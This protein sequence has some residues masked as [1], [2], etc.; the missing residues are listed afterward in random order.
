MGEIRVFKTLTK[1][2]IEIIN[3]EMPEFIR[4]VDT[5]NIDLELLAKLDPKIEIQI[6]GNENIEG[7]EQEKN[8]A[9]IYGYTGE[10]LSGI[11]GAL[12][13]IEQGISDNPNWSELDKAVYLYSK[14]IYVFSTT[15]TNNELE[16]DDSLRAL[17]SGIPTPK[18]MA[19]IYAELCRRNGIEARYVENSDHTD[20]FNE[21]KI[22]DNYY[23]VDNYLDLQES[24]K[25][26]GSILIHNFGKNVEFYEMPTHKTSRESTKFEPLKREE[27]Q[28]SLD[29]VIGTIAEEMRKA[30][31]LYKED[32]IPKKKLDQK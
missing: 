6:V 11:I 1:E 4:I 20:A 22:G 10:E 12:K 30:A 15:G 23:P 9:P 25:S 16:R 3:E 27:V 21:V 31:S 8:S 32:P 13:Y 5:R 18:S 19:L 7:K 14:L 28:S 2:D 24:K 26:P 29:R 17:A